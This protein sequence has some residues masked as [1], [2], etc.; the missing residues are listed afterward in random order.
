VRFQFF[1]AI[2]LY[3]SGVKL[4]TSTALTSSLNPSVVGESVTFTASVSAIGGAPVGSVRFKT[5]NVIVATFL[6]SPNSFDCALVSSARGQKKITAIFA[7]TALLPRV[8]ATLIAAS[9]LAVA[10]TMLAGE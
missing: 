10:G 2:G 3:T 4:P 7:G 8:S 6:S 1:L 5:G 9:E